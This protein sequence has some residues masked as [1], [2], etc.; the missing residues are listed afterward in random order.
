[1]VLNAVVRQQEILWVV[2]RI[3]LDQCWCHPSCVYPETCHDRGIGAD[4]G[5]LLLVHE[6]FYM[7]L[8]ILTYIPDTLRVPINHRT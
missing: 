2:G 1:M 8:H 5:L 7:I 4:G 6:Y 3:P